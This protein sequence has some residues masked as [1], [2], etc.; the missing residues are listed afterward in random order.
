MALI[1]KVKNWLG[2]EGVKIALATSETFKLKDGRVDGAYSI[3]TQSDQFIK[4]IRLIFKEK[5]ARGRRKSKLIDE[6]ILA[7]KTII[8]DQPIAKDEV[9][10]NEFTLDFGLLKSPI[11]KF[12][13][14]NLFYKGLSSVAKLLKNAKSQY[15]ITAE[16]TVEGNKLKPYDTQLLVAS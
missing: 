8:V 15:S 16:V 10:T 7:E 3:S 6:F 9:I 14:K 1:K 12:G 11:D 4:S 2:I 5:Y 13:D